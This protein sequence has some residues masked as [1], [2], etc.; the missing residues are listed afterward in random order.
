MA[1][2][3]QLREMTCD[4]KFRKVLITD[5]KSALGQA[6]V[7]AIVAAGADLVWAGY[8]EPWK[9]PPGFDRLASIPQ[10]SL[11]RSISPTRARSRTPPARSAGASIS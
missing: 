4:P 11:L 3:R 7:E 6:L 9:K 8:A 1:D 10:V 2:D 5:A